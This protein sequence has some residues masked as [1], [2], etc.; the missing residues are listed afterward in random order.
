MTS[1][2]ACTGE[3]LLDGDTF[4]SSSIGAT[5]SMAVTFPLVASIAAAFCKWQSLKLAR[6]DFGPFNRSFTGESLGREVSAKT[7]KSLTVWFRRNRNV[8]EIEV[9]KRKTIVGFLRLPHQTPRAGLA[10]VLEPRHRTFQRN[11]I[12]A[13]PGQIKG[14]DT[15]RSHMHTKV[16]K[17]LSAQGAQRLSK[18]SRLSKK[19]LGRNSY[20]YQIIF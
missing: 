19:G 8:L 2:S 12:R 9:E 4:R 14:T 15:R 10:D 20:T 3:V 13:G 1:G 18:L 6:C 7:L 16:I 11:N 17:V 5:W